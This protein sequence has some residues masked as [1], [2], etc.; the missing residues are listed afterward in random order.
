MSTILLSIKSKRKL[1]YL[2]RLTTR[3]LLLD[4]H[5]NLRRLLSDRLLGLGYIKVRWPKAK[6]LSIPLLI[7]N[8]KSLVWSACTLKR[9]KISMKQELEIFLLYSVLT[10]PLERPSAIRL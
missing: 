2:W 5:S 6:L 10:V 3:S 8:A 1:K 7:R 9:W 4:W